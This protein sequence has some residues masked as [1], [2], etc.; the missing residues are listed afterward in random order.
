MKWHH[1]GQRWALYCIKIL[2]EMS[3]TWPY[4]L[5]NVAL[6]L[7]KYGTISCQMWP[8]SMS[9]VTQFHVK[10]DTIPCQ[11]W[12]YSM[13]NVT[14]FHVKCDVIPCQMW[15]Y[16][17]SNVALFHIQCGLRYHYITSPLPQANRMFPEDLE[18]FSWFVWYQNCWQFKGCLHTRPTSAVLASLQVYDLTLF[19]RHPL[20]VAIYNI[21][22][23]LF[24]SACIYMNMFM[25]N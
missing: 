15:H 10:C 1:R 8:Y 16:S 3:R 23:T 12:R 5:P 25:Y 9:N 17:M 21:P 20:K 19:Y 14:L 24:G 6:F 18:T 11:M 2:N 22:D 13:S 7:V 4:S